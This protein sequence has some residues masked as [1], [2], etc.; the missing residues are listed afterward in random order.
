AAPTPVP[1]PAV[2][3]A[4]SP[5]PATPETPAAPN[6]DTQ[7]DFARKGMAAKRYDAAIAGAQAVL[8]IDPGNLE[9]KQVLA[10]ALAA[11]LRAKQRLAQTPHEPQPNE[12]MAAT[13]PV[14]PVT[15][16]P[17]SPGE[18]SSQAAATTATLRVHFVCDFPDG[19][20]LIV[21]VNDKEKARLTVEASRGGFL[22]LRKSVQ[23]HDTSKSIEVPA[24]TVQIRA[25]VTPTGRAAIVRPMNGNFQGGVPRNLE[26]Q[27]SA[28]GTVSDPSL[29]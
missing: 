3:P 16:V 19:G 9:A 5:A 10:R 13:T 14:I 7:L 18:P 2:T 24:G 17:R 15:A 22:R 12:T 11:Q 20:V 6:L 25:S 27:L 29:R 1:P 4:A 8:M 23:Q 28:D 21:Y 26:V